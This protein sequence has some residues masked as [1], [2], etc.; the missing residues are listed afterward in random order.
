MALCICQAQVISRPHKK[1]DS[2]MPAGAHEPAE[3]ARCSPQGLQEAAVPEELTA[4]LTAAHQ[5]AEQ[6]IESAA[7]F[8]KLEGRSPPHAPTAAA[9]P[10]QAPTA[11]AGPPAKE[12]HAQPF[13]SRIS[14]SIML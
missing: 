1:P 14:M 9:P 13:D 7:L 3:N 8:A 4:W 5:A 12:V 2:C 10:A 11:T 6:A